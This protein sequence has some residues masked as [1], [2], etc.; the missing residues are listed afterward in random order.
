MKVLRSQIPPS[1]L[2][3][4]PGY[5]QRNPHQAFLIGLSIVASLP[6]LRGQA[7]SSL[8]EREL[9]D[10]T[11]VLWGGCLLVGSLL[12]LFGEFWPGRTWTGLVLE[13]GG[14]GLIGGAAAVYA[15]VTWSSV[16][17]HSPLVEMLPWALMT[18]ITTAAGVAVHGA[19]KLPPYQR[20]DLVLRIVVGALLGLLLGGYAGAVWHTDAATSG[21]TYV[22][23]IQAAYAGACLWRVAQ[24]TARLRWIRRLVQAHSLE[25][26]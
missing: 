20:A 5:S 4:D 26:R 6:L 19:Y 11:V 2:L 18:A 21:V 23:S 25:E 15:V 3:D 7:Q 9:D 14:L 8:L 16:G 10:R 13:R 17:N 12:A 1:E 22:V 24:I